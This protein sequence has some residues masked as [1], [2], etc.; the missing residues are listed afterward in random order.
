M[1]CVLLQMLLTD[2]EQLTGFAIAD[3]LDCFRLL[4]LLREAHRFQK[5][6]KKIVVAF[7]DHVH[8]ACRFPIAGIVVPM[9]GSQRAQD[10][11]RLLPALASVVHDRENVHLTDV[12]RL[13]EVGPVLL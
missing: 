10:G 2:V 1:S 6:V 11:K 9:H 12:A 3:F 13:L 7:H 4:L 5:V 8:E